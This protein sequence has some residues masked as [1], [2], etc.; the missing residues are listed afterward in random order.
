MTVHDDLTA[1]WLHW[2][3]ATLFQTWVKH[4]PGEALK[5]YSYRNGGP[6]PNLATATGRALVDETAA[7]LATAP[8]PNVPAPP[9]LDNPVVFTCKSGV[10]NFFDANGRDAIVKSSGLIAQ[11]PPNDNAIVTLKN[12]G[13]A[14][15]EPLAVHADH[16][17]QPGV[18]NGYG[19]GLYLIGGN[20]VYIEDYFASGPGLAQALVIAGGT[21]K[22]QVVQADWSVMHPVWH[23][24]P[25]KRYP[26]GAPAE[27]HTDAIQS[28]GGPGVLEL[29]DVKAETCGSITQVQPYKGA[30][31][32][33][34]LWK[35]HRCDFAQ[36]R[37][38]DSD[39]MPQAMTK[40]PSGGAKWPT[41]FLDCTLRPLGTP[42]TVSWVADEQ[43]WQPGGT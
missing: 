6:R 40:D 8:T 28:Y 3:T 15:V 10:P 11:G 34:G 38:P 41:E 17:Q 37:N 18:G 20:T 43:A 32:P 30:L 23:L 2:Q 27:V 4:N 24:A 16:R 5:L 22:V 12:P 14:I 39:E 31:A 9:R 36:V 25:S 42:F 13:N 35:M 1:A 33:M 21:R 26:N 19:Y 29:Y 7:W